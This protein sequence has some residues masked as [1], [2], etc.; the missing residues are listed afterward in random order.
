[1]VFRLVVLVLVSVLLIKTSLARTQRRNYMN[2]VTLTN[3][4]KTGKIFMLH[5]MNY[6]TKQKE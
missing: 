2:E 4:H 6:V 1:M 3:F 5:C